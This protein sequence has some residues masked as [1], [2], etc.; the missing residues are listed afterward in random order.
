LAVAYARG[1]KDAEAER[2]FEEG[3][4]LNPRSAEILGRL[5]DFWVARNDRPRAVARLKLYL[6]KYP[7]DA[8]A[9][10]ILGFLESGA[11]QFEAAKAEFERAI[12]L[13]PN[14]ALAY[15]R[16]GQVYQDQGQT[17]LA[18][19]RFEKALALQPMLVPLITLVGNLYLDK[20][21]FE[22]AG[23]YYQ[24]ALAIDPNFA[25][26]A[27]NLAWVYAAQGGNLDVALSLAEKAKES[28]PESDSAS[29]VLAWVEYKKGSYDSA[30][31]LLEE[32]VQKVPDKGEYHYHLGMVLLASG[33]KVKARAALQS[34][35]RLKLKPEDATQ[36]RQALARS[37]SEA[38]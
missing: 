24:Q 15:L 29:D 33:E 1:H 26:A 9:H 23:K 20:G 36:A 31:E 34:A 12:Q 2:E 32:C 19:G 27:S 28:L 25:T 5:A 21:N 13:D 17:D 38:R 6:A 3:L 16:L 35:L 37:G 4:R 22:V 14:L 18:I 30:R 7:D 8:N 11:A 10:Q